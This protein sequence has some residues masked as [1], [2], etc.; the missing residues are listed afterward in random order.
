M[1]LN[2]TDEELEWIQIKETIM[3]INPKRVYY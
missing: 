1:K 2:L 3:K